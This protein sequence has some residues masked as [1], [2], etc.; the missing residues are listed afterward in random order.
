MNDVIRLI[1]HTVSGNCITN[2]VIIIWLLFF[3]LKSYRINTRMW[4]TCVA[5][6]ANASW[7]TGYCFHREAFICQIPIHSSPKTPVEPGRVT[8]QLNECANERRSQ[9]QTNWKSMPDYRLLL[10]NYTSPITVKPTSI[11]DIITVVTPCSIKFTVRQSQTKCIT[12]F[13]KR[14]SKCETLPWRRNNWSFLMP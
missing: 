14:S 1:T 11:F 6:N 10:K 7:S 9:P 12:R 4:M 8:V 5:A 13:M 3:L 2:V